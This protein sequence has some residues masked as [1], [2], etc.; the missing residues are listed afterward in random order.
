MRIGILILTITTVGTLASCASEPI[1]NANNHEAEMTRLARTEGL[2]AMRQYFEA[3]KHLGQNAEGKT[4]Q[5]L[6]LDADGWGYNWEQIEERYNNYNRPILRRIE[7]CKGLK[8]ARRQVECLAEKD[9]CSLGARSDADGCSIRSGDVFSVELPD[10]IP[11]IGWR[12]VT[13]VAQYREALAA[14]VAGANAEATGQTQV[15]QQ[16][17]EKWHKLCRSK[18]YGMVLRSTILPI[19]RFQGNTFWAKTV[20]VTPYAAWLCSDQAQ[21]KNVL[22]MQCP[23]DPHSSCAV[24]AG[25]ADNTQANTY[26]NAVLYYAG[27]VKG[28]SGLGFSQDKVPLWRIVPKDMLA[29]FGVGD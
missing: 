25:L 20:G 13:V 12:N 11:K 23:G 7:N 17:R 18:K 22:Y 4:E 16:A 19:N 6:K 8:P 29:Q 26:V 21:S 2:P 27:T 9:L 15:Q 1:S 14:S 24:V 10:K 5:L 28:Q 3:N